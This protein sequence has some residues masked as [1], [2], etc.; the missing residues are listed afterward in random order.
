MFIYTH[1]TDFPVS[2]FAIQ[3]FVCANYFENLHI[4]TVKLN[5]HHSHITGK[6]QGYVH[7]F[8]N[9]KVHENENLMSCLAHKF[10]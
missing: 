2:N 8:C 5:L 6:I 9:D 4:I 7:D 10:F 3:T 1:L